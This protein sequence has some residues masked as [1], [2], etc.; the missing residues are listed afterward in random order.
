MNQ[1]HKIFNLHTPPYG[2]DQ[3]K[4]QSGFHVETTDIQ[5]N[6]NKQFYSWQLTTIHKAI[7]FEL[8]DSFD[9]SKFAIKSLHNK[10]QVI[11][12]HK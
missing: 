12:A 1:L 7:S 10:V 8:I 3:S 2:L 11:N 5:H 6:Q 4:F 9:R